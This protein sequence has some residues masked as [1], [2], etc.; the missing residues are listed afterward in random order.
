M[1]FSLYVLMS[2]L[3]Y[4]YF[5]IYGFMGYWVIENFIFSA[6]TPQNIRHKNIKYCIIYSIYYH[7]RGDVKMIQRSLKYIYNIICDTDLK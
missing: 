7:G 1:N 4:V 2:T 3:V 6:L 5:S